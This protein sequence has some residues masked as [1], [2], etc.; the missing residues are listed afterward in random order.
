MKHSLVSLFFI[1]LFFQSR[2]ADTTRV[3]FIGNS[4]TYFNNMPQM[5]KSFADSAGITMT[6]SMHAPGGVSVGDT[7]QGTLA[8]MNNPAVYTMIRSQKWDYVVIQDN[9]GRFVRDS[10]QFPGSSKVVEGHIKIRDSVVANNSCAKVVLFGGWGLKNGL[11]PYGNTGVEMI[12]RI[13]TNYY[14]LNDTM[15]EV[16]APIGE[17]WIKTINYL[18]G[19]DPWSPDQQHPS[20]EGSY[21]TAAVI[22]SSVFQ[23]PV[24]NIN[25]HAGIPSSVSNV[26]KAYSD[27]VLA[28]PGMHTHYNLGGVQRITIQMNGSVLQVNGSYSSYAWYK[29]GVP[30]GSTS[31]L[32]ISGNGTYSLTVVDASACTIKSCALTVLTTQLNE[33]AESKGTVSVYPNPSKGEDVF[34]RGENIQQLKLVDLTGKKLELFYSTLEKETKLHI[35]DLAPGCYYLSYEKDTKSYHSRILIER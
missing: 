22:F 5:V 32:A 4:F 21:L 27:T 6:F 14:V 12:R 1:F 2:S 30:M 25:Y 33:E 16:I 15:K 9:Q 31:T 7:A 8:H 18:P 23:T 26:L 28:N 34:I 19:T 24:K 11:P 3:L 13:L 10:A 29:N 35:G 17:A 20:Q